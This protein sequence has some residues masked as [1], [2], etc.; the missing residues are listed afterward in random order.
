[1]HLAPGLTESNGGCF[2]LW[3]DDD[4]AAPR[5]SIAPLFNRAVV[6]LN[7][8]TAFHSVS[9]THLGPG[10]ARKVMQALYFTESYPGS[11]GR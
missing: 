11:D 4:R 8:P 3:D 6:F 1:L 7:S 10:Q 2:Q 5:A 9:R